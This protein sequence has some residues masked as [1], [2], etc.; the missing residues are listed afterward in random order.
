MVLVDA[1]PREAL[2][3]SITRGACFSGDEVLLTTPAT[4]TAHLVA[5][6]QIQMPLVEPT[7]FKRGKAKVAGAASTAP[8]LARGRTATCV[9]ET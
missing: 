7:L 1:R 2:S 3:F 5:R 8:W 4:R 6:T 9:G